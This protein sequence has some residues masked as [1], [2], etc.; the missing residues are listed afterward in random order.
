MAGRIERALEAGLR[1][2]PGEQRRVALMA[3]YAANA[4]GAIVVGRSLRDALFL[5]DAHRR[6]Q[7]AGMYVWSSIAIVLVSYGYARIA[8]KMPRGQLNSASALFSGMLCAAFWALLSLHDSAT[9]IYYALYIFVEAMGSLVVIQF[10]TMANDV[11]HAREAKRLFG[12]IGAGGTLANVI[13]G[14]LVSRYA[15]RIGA[16]NLL[17]LMVVQLTT[18]A[19]LARAGARLI[20]TAPL[21]GMRRARRIV[22]VLSRA[23]IAFLGNRHLMLVAAVAAVSAAAVTVVDFQFKL[24]AASVLPQNEL[25][26]YFGRFYGI[27]GGIALA[28]Q[29]W[30]TGRLLERHGILAS[31]LPLPAGL[32][33]GSGFS[34]ALPN[35]GLF[36]ASLAKGSDTIF[37]YTINDASMQLLYVPVQPSVRGRAKA[38]IDGILKPTA[39]ALTGVVLLFYKE[40]GGKGRPLTFAVL[41]LVGLWILF[42]VRARSE[43]VRSLVES[44]ER[45]QL[46]LTATPLAAT[47]DA[48]VRALRIALKG[49]AATTLHAISL[50]QHVPGVD[51]SAE[52]RDLLAHPDPRIR[53]GAVE[54][55][56]EAGVET[57]H[58]AMRER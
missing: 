54:Q 5:S 41:L 44:L 7:L 14:L 12:L 38:F 37:R 35:P 50:L 6:G 36:V 8:D 26:G 51:F 4:V 27:C 39:I 13:F 1:I 18:C 23:G 11:F 16:P 31:L 9:W 24:A 22:P 46:D 3:A 32:A 40:S 55:L 49:D 15:R 21:I 28:V 34:A 52:L 56:G 30:I 25:A 43:Y 57:A 45:R 20:S 58:G 33:L 29:I 42:L 10:W 47:S 2:R 19:L 48:T 53:S 17:W